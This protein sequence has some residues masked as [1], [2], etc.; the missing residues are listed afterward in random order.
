MN[1]PC[2]CWYFALVFDAVAVLIHLCV[3]CH[4][5]SG[6][7]S[8]FQG[9][10]TCKNLTLLKFIQKILKAVLMKINFMSKTSLTNTKSKNSETSVVERLTKG[11]FPPK[12]T[13][14]V[15]ELP[16]VLKCRCYNDK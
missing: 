12:G 4:H 8:L 1:K 9:H 7:M 14:L 16:K 13:S 10:I 5:F 6:L 3:I 11:Q 15:G 2:P